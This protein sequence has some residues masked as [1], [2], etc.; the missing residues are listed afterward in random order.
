MNLTAEEL[1]D[2]AENDLRRA[3]EEL[4]GKKLVEVLGLKVKDGRIQTDWGNKSY[5]GLTQTI[6]KIL[7]GKE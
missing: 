3:R 1:K 2:L 7:D 6:Q 4:I 5:I